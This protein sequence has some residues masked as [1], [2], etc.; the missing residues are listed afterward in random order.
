MR[1]NHEG[2]PEIVQAFEREGQYFGVVGI[3][4][5][6]TSKQFQFGVSVDGYRALTK[7]LQLRPF[8]FMPGLK[9]RHFFAQS[10]GKIPGSSDYKTDIRVELGRDGKQ[11]EVRVPKDL[12]TN[13]V[14][15]SEIKDL[16]EAAHLPEFT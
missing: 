3:T 4:L 12:L 7:I 5:G 10:Y 14:W 2:M 15:F 9:H 11:I 13:L 6:D 8:D 1:D 16:D